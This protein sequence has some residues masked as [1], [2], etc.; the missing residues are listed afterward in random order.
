MKAFES[1]EGL[2]GHADGLMKYATELALADAEV[3]GDGFYTGVGQLFGGLECEVRMG[4]A[5]L[6]PGE[7]FGYCG[8]ED[9][10]RIGSDVRAGES[11]Q[12]PLCRGFTPQVIEGDDASGDG[13]GG[14]AEHSFCSAQMEAHGNRSLAGAN[15][16]STDSLL[17]AHG[18]DVETLSSGGPEAG[19]DLDF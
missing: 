9:C 12:E 13:G 16:F 19:H 5:G 1:G 2:R 7:A 18:M 4:V 14:Y 6:Y 3:G 10:G 15:E 17:R 8:L 11:I